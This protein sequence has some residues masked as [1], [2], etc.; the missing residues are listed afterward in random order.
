MT[1]PPRHLPRPRGPVAAAT[2]AA[3]AFREG[4]PVAIHGSDGTSLSYALETLTSEALA[5]VKDGAL[6]LTHAR[7]R[8]LKIRL[9]TPDVV[10][11]PLD[12][13]AAPETLLTIADPTFD[14]AAP[15]KGPFT[16]LRDKLP[17]AFAASVK[18]AKLAGLL[19][20]TVCVRVAE[21]PSHSISISV[22]DPQDYESESVDTLALVTRARVPLEGAEDAELVAFRARDG[23]AEHYAIL[24]HAPPPHETVLARVHSECFTGDLL[25]SLRCD[26]GPQLRGAI[27]T[28]AKSGGGIV[29]YLAQE[30]RGIGLINKLRAYRLQDQGFDTMEANE[31]LGF[32]ADERLYRVAAK[33]L[34]LLGYSSVRLLTN[35]PAKAEALADAGI[36]VVARVPHRF[37]GTT[38]NRG[39][40]AAKAKAGHLL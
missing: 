33:M 15:L 36:E 24:I 13:L 20:A 8:T 25:G 1:A 16:P 39:Y 9:Y 6:V 11:L 26:C 37:A 3:I 40:L 35:N 10:A 38:H 17:D 31:R 5:E 22:T 18:L 23:G 28:I 7:A 30:G 2:R 32:E 12:A 19:P 27:E 29:L 34:S 21:A 4:L 14:L